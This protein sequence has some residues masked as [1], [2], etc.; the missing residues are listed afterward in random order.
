MALPYLCN[1]LYARFWAA[2]G[3]GVTGIVRRSAAVD[4]A[5]T[6]SS[7]ESDVEARL[8]G[9]LQHFAGSVLYIVHV[10]LRGLHERGLLA[11]QASV[12]LIVTVEKTWE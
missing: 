4:R 8:Q 1:P 10:V 7:D 11:Q 3:A 12:T 2:P 6:D 5:S 9:N